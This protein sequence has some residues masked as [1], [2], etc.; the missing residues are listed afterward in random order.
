[1]LLGI[2]IAT[3]VLLI[4]IFLIFKSADKSY[5]TYHE[6]VPKV[7]IKFG[8][9]MIIIVAIAFIYFIFIGGK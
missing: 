7:V 8:I 4:L 5:Y 6:G 3:V 9:I 2:I 1:M